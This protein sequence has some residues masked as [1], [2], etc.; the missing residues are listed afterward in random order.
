MKVSIITATYNSSKTLKSCIDSVLT[1]DYGS[2]EYII[3]D[4]Q[5]TDSTMDIVN[6]FTASYSNI[7]VVSENDE[8]IYD[9]LNK[10]LSIVTG[11]IIG[12]LHSDDLF[13]SVTIISE[14][15]SKI[16]SNN[17]D[18]IYGDLQ[19]VN[20]E[21]TNKIVRLWKSCEFKLD[22][23]R[24]GWMP[25][26]PT[27]FL[28]KHVYQK[29]G[30]FNT[31]YEISADYDFMLRILKDKA[32]KFGYLPKVITK[33]RVGGVSNRS[34]RNILIKIK[35]D[36]RAVCSNNIGGW[37]SIFLKNTSKIRQFVIKQ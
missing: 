7:K 30:D 9:A 23:L 17:F 32:L 8:G 37:F 18:G 11:D 6:N 21:N 24:K 4:G 1:Q 31:S 35:E 2:I 19:Y 26:H 5:S 22:L 36:Y 10:G 27:L 25:A 12:F 20:K 33:M 34:F 16:N 14:L 29:Y 3:I 15:V 28:K 13:S